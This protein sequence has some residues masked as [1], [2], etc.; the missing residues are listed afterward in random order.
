[1]T[2]WIKDC[3]KNRCFKDGWNG[4]KGNC[5]IAIRKRIKKLK[6]LPYNPLYY[7]SHIVCEMLK[8]ERD[9]LK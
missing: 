1:M 8:Y 4:H 3:I 2:N 9:K 7:D 5:K 6:S